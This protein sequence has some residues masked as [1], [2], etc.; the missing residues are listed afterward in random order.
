MSRHNLE[1]R[2]GQHLTLTPALQQSIRLLQMSTLEL[3]LELA[4]ALADN[5]MLEHEQEGL[6]E[7]QAASE[8]VEPMESASDADERGEIA[9]DRPDNKPSSILNR[10]KATLSV[11]TSS[12]SS[13]PICVA[14]HQRM[15]L[16]IAT[17]Q[18]VRVVCK[19]ICLSS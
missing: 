17:N 9:F 19:N 10:V 16:A 8:A 5:P 2:H 3:E 7:L 6:E 14:R 18:R 4:N 12:K 13:P 11:R 1:L 15:I